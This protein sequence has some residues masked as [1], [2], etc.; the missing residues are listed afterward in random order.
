MKWQALA[1]EVWPGVAEWQA[2]H[3][4]ATF[5]EIER[6]VAERLTRIRT[7][8]LNDAALASAARDSAGQEERPACGECGAPSRR[9]ANRNVS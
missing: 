6:A 5:A 9:V 2:A 4:R 3:P 8:L 1:E 7:H